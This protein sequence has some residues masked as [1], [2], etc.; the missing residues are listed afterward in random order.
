MLISQS[1]V[2]YGTF[3]QT[4]PP[5]TFK[6]RP[7][8]ISAPTKMRDIQAKKLKYN[9]YIAY[10]DANCDDALVDDPKKWMARDSS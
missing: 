2:G 10:H 8:M 5:L 9:K 7:Q 3:Q 6:M 1:C 4:N